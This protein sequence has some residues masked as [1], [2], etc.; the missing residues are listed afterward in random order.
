M[1]DLEQSIERFIKEIDEEVAKLPPGSDLA[2]F[3]TGKH[4]ELGK[5]LARRIAEK[6]ENASQE[7]GFSP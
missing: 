5:M 1:S 4:R 6:R 7:A 2:G 3:I